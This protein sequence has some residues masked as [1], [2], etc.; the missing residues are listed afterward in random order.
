MNI[1]YYHNNCGSKIYRAFYPAKFISRKT[2]HQTRLRDPHD[3]I[4]SVDLEW[5]DVVVLEM[6][7]DGKAFDVFDRRKQSTKPVAYI[8]EID[9][10]MHEINPNNPASDEWSVSTQKCFEKMMQYCDGMTVTTDYLKEYYSGFNDSIAVIPNSLDFD[11]WGRGYVPNRS[12]VLRIG[13]AGGISHRDDLMMVKPAIKRILEKYP[14]TK[15]VHVGYGGSGSQDPISE[16]VY[17]TDLFEDIDPRRRELGMSTWPEDWPRRLG[18][19]GFDIG[20]APVTDD[21]WNWAKSNLKY[22]EYASF[23]VPCVA[24]GGET[25]TKLPYSYTIKEGE[26]GLLAAT[27]DEWV[28][29]LSALIESAELRRKIG[30][31]GRQKAQKLYNMDKNYILWLNYYEDVYKNLK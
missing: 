13:W 8:Y 26:D 2:E 11:V 30:E 1:L 15:F 18:T 27:E 31:S 5:A 3:G 23:G 10:L 4:H 14:N 6:I 22:L 12:K 24:S 21:S 28:G 29:K 17:G 20:I 16:V 7:T 25:L 19:L 9:D